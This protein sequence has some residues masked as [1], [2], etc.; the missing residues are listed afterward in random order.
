MTFNTQQYLARIN[1]QGGIT[2]S[3]AT[4]QALQ[5]QHLYTVP[6]E[7]WDI[8]DK[9]AIELD[10]DK[11]FNKVVI[12]DRGGFCY[13]LN[14]LFCRLLAELG[15]DAWLVSAQVY[16]ASSE[17]YGKPFDHMAIVVTI[18]E[19]N[20]LVDVGFGEFAR[21]PLNLNQLK[22]I[23]QLGRGGMFQ[24]EYID[25]MYVV[26]KRHQGYWC[27]EYKFDLIKRELAEFAE[28]CHYHQTSPQSHFTQKR[29]FSLATKT[30]GRKTVSGN[31][32]IIRDE[33]DEIEEQTLSDSQANDLAFVKKVVCE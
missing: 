27:A 24:L 21:V 9:V 11:M 1:Y 6:F 13:E 19:V 5:A 25:N 10:I 18:D 32:L 15:F 16:S 23:V 31:M 12:N 14:G 29:L 17:S 30:Y 3:L 4:L 33:T 8:H 22:P 7:N 26:N 28:M 20:Y 2:P